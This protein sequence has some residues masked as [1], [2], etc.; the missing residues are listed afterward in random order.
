M[1]GMRGKMKRAKLLLPMIAVLVIVVLAIALRGGEKK[2]E[3]AEREAPPVNATVLTVAETELPNEVSASGTVRPVLESQIAP[4]I[5]SNVTAVYAR[6]GDH[7]SKG[8]LLVKLESRDLQAQV[9]QAGAALAAAHAGSMRASTAVELQK[10]QTSTGIA[11]AQAAL[12]AAREQLSVAQEGPRKQQKAQAKLGV[13]QAQAQFKNAEIEL[14]RMQRLYDQGVVP[15]QRLDGAQTAYDVAKAQ[16]ESAQEQADLMD[17][18]TRKQDIRTA[19]EKVRQAEEALRLAKASAVQDTMSKRDAQVASSQ[20]AQA[21]AGLQYAQTQL[22][23]STIV[24]PMSG[25]VTSRLVDP[26]DTVSPGM[27]IIAIEDDSLY[28]L[29]ATVPAGDVGNLYVGRVVRVSIDSTAKTAEGRV[30]EISP[31]GDPSTRTFLVKVDLPRELKARTGDF[32][33][34]H[35]PVSFSRGI[36]VPEAAVRDD[37]GL[38][39]VFIVDDSSR[40]R[41]QVVKTGRSVDGGIEIVSGLT[42]G[43]KVILKSSGVLEDGMRV[44]IGRP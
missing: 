19:Q 23:Y 32:G 20:V 18:G 7:V 22:G 17:E 25:V 14:G 34:I 8:Q 5:M 35:F 24:A 44:K 26:G 12:A 16:Y 40:A 15:K 21:R 6:E 29:E 39:T 41:L 43:T 11:S 38:T 3:A 37:G 4:K 31:A 42:P 2:P 30:S 10:A 9:S 1:S 27:P 33:R 13:A 28:R 36:V